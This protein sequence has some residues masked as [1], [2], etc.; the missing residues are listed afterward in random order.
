MNIVGKFLFFISSYVPLLIVI[1]INAKSNL[2][3]MLGYTIDIFW[4][5][6]SINA[7][8]ILSSV[9]FLLW[10]LNYR[11]VNNRKIEIVK[12]ENKTSETLSYILPYIVSFY[13]VDFSQ[14][15]NLLTFMIMFIT[16]FGVYMNSN[17]LAI[18]PLL[19]MLGYKIFIIDTTKQKVF[20]IS[21]NNISLYDKEIQAKPVCCN[22]YIEKGVRNGF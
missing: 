8:L 9:A 20:L 3:S 18:N 16:I 15:S 2:I 19:A 11:R 12:I 22:I 17:L 5:I 10:F 7:I 1:N 4:I 6:F 13:Q 21:R 14:I